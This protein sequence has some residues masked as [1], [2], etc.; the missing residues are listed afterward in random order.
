MPTW[1]AIS[2]F[3]QPAYADQEIYYTT[4][5]YMNPNDSLVASIQQYFKT[6]FYS[7]PSDMVFRGYETMFRFAQLLQEYGHNL[8]GSIGEKKFKVFNDFDIEPVFLNKQNLTLDYFENK[9]LYFIKKVNGNVVAV[10]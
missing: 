8:N 5:F 10:Y 3:S 9:K 1:D 7:R 2:D 4:P 6:R